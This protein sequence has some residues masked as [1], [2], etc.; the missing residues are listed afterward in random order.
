MS[1][2]LSRWNRNDLR[3]YSSILAL[4]ILLPLSWTAP[5]VAPWEY[6]LALWLSFLPLHIACIRRILFHLDKEGT[7][8]YLEESKFLQAIRPPLEARGL[9]VGVRR[10]KRWFPTWST[11]DTEVVISD[12]VGQV[13]LYLKAV[14][15]VGIYEIVRTSVD[16]GP[17]GGS[18]LGF[19]R[20]V[21]GLVEDGLRGLENDGP[22]VGGAAR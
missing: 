22:I 6:N 10:L 11:H 16:I 8:F 17:R 14:R 4:A 9:G 20:M 7:S 5:G 21:E 19:V 2:T 18:G 3:A 12:G 1:M 13:L 15:I